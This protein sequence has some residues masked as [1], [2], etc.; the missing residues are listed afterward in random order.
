MHKN[1]DKNMH[2]RINLSIKICINRWFYKSPP[3]VFAV[4]GYLFFSDNGTGF[5]QKQQSLSPVLLKSL[6]N[7]VHNE[8]K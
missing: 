5:S 2:K 3:P 6:K 4:D 7:K 8:N 1:I